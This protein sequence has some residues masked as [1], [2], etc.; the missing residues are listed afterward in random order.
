MY[1]LTTLKHCHEFSDL[2]P[3]R[4]GL[5]NCADAVQDCIAV[6]AAKRFKKGGGHRI[7]VQ[8][9]LKITGDMRAA[10]RGVCPIPSPICNSR[11]DLREASGPYSP[12]FH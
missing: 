3:S 6:S 7:L 11:F 4:L 1:C 12:L 5:F 2:S 9:V 10:G 8:R